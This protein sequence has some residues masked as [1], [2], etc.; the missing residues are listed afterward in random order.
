MINRLLLHGGHQMAPLLRIAPD[1]GAV[2]ASCDDRR[3]RRS[4]NS[5]A[6]CSVEGNGLMGV[7][8]KAL[9]T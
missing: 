5:N 6:T 8:A 2:L 7:A 9:P 4:M 3:R 1:F